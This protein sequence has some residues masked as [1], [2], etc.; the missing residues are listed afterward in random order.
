[1]SN[2]F[3]SRSP[4]LAGPATDLQPV[5]PDDTQDLPE[6]AI[7]LYV[8]TGGTLSIVTVEGAQR[9]LSVTD[10]SFLPVGVTKVLDTGTTASGIHALVIA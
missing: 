8:E 3:A 9:S 5:S 1:M 2:P 6:V 4:S 7:A 10:W